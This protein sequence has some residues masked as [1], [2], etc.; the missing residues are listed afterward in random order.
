MRAIVLAAATLAAA[1]PSAALADDDITGTYKLVVDQRRI[2]DTG[3][4]IT[5]P[6]PQGYITYGKEGRMMVIIVR[7]PRPKPAV[8]DNF[9]DQE[10]VGLHKT[11]S[12]YGGTYKF[13]G[14]TVKHNVD[15]AWNEVWT[16]I[17]QER[18]VTREGDRLTL[19]TPQYRNQTDGRM[20]VNILVWEK[21][22]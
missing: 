7:Q 11:M 16:G 14:K 13:D 2:V 10:R 3:E 9:T 22:K 21:V 17:T 8:A 20:S 6:T 12:A 18:S 19:T 4:V 1:I 5:G 15:I